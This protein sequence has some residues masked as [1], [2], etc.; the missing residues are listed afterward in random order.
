MVARPEHARQISRVGR[1]R[2]CPAEDVVGV[3]AAEDDR[4]VEPPGDRVEVVVDPAYDATG[5]VTHQ[6]AAALRPLPVENEVR[7]GA[8]GIR[9]AVDHVLHRL[10]QRVVVRRGTF[11]GIERPVVVVVAENGLVERGQV[12][13]D[14]AVGAGRKRRGVDAASQAEADR[15]ADPQDEDTGTPVH[16]QHSSGGRRRPRNRSSSDRGRNRGSG[17]WRVGARKCRTGR[18]CFPRAAR[19][20]S[21]RGSASARR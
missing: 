8:S 17:R 16:R 2:L 7:H 9:A 18:R 5:A 13:E 3:A 14:T 12:A 11:A 20:G 4:E 10:R 6:T 21:R 15:R 19:P 1:V